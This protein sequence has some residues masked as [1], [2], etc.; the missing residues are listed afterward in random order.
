MEQGSP[1]QR[2]A[3]GRGCG[4]QACQMEGMWYPSM[5]DGRG[6]V[7]KD[8]GWKGCGTQGC[9]RE[10]MQYLGMQEGGDVVSI[11]TIS[12]PLMLSSR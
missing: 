5:R 4:T 10:W 9:R 11:D 2:D 6:A 8:V 3:G 1:A 12:S 7:P